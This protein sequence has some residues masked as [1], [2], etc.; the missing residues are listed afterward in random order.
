MLSEYYKFHKDFARF[1]GLPVEAVMARYYDKRRD[2]DYKR[3]RKMLREQKKMD[4][5]EPEEEESDSMMNHS[6]YVKKSRYSTMLA[7]LQDE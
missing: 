1:Y 5:D 2:F 7:A 3:I 6:S 4:F